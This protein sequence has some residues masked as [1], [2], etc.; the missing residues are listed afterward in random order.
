[1][2][3]EIFAFQEVQAISVFS[4][5][6][7][8][9]AETRTLTSTEKHLNLSVTETVD[10]VQLTNGINAAVAGGTLF[11]VSITLTVV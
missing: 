9:F 1:M 11:T 8:A 6:F 10:Q 5:A 3:A 7:S 2:F 4:M